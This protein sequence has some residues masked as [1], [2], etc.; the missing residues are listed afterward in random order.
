[1]KR[2]LSFGAGV[3]TTALAILLAQGKI[4]VDEVVFADTGAEK[5]ETYWYMEAYTI[6]LFRGSRIPFTIVKQ[7]PLNLVELCRSKKLIPS[8]IKRWC[9]DKAKQTPIRRYIGKEAISIIGF[10]SDEINRADRSTNKATKSFPLID[11]GISVYDCHRI[12]SDYGWPMPLK[13]S[14]YFCPFQRWS[15]WNCMKIHHTELIQACVDMEMNYYERRPNSRH[16]VGLFGGKPLW[17]WAEGIQMEWEFP[18][19][20]SCWSGDCGH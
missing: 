14:C 11:M 3:Q 7:T 6:P 15:E 18:G 17:M 8:I 16:T 10:S 4:E 2:I 19:E 1:M 5:P 13:S 12:I 20:Y 9:S